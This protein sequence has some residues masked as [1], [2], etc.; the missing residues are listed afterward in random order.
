MGIR[1]QT[2][3]RD[4]ARFACDDAES[5]LR[6]VS[7]EHC[8][9]RPIH[10]GARLLR[11]RHPRLER[12]RQESTVLGIGS[13]LLEDFCRRR[14]IP[15]HRLYAGP[16]DRHRDRLFRNGAA[17]QRTI[18]IGDRGASAFFTSP[19]ARYTPASFAMS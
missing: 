9:L 2:L 15:E 10:P 8:R 13:R 16:C 17:S 11:R 5:R 4:R 12:E 19:S 6:R 1:Q 14:P 18:G 3:A 7:L